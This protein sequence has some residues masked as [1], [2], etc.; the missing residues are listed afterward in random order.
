MA[1]VKIVL[2]AGFLIC[3]VE[4]S[5]LVNEVTIFPCSVNGFSS[6]N[7][8]SGS[9]FFW[10]LKLGAIFTFKTTYTEGESNEGL[11]LYYKRYFS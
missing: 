11:K 5:V 6:C 3:R 2:H 9:C 4:T 8:P 10:R 1:P 7:I